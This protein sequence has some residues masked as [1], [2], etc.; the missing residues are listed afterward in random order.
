VLIGLAALVGIGCEARRGGWRRLAVWGQLPA[1]AFFYLL[2]FP[3]VTVHRGEALT[4]LTPGITAAQLRSI[5]AGQ[6]VVLLPGASGPARAQAVPD[7]ATALRRFP[8]VGRIDVIGAGLPARDRP[9]A[10]NLALH[11]DATAD[12]GLVELSAPS[13]A[14]VGRQWPVIGK[15]ASHAGLRLELRDPSGAVVDAMPATPDGRF[16]LS[17]VARGIGPALFSLH[18]LDAKAAMVD[19]ISVPVWVRDGETLTILLRAGG[20]SPEVKYW[21]RWAADSGQRVAATI[22]LTEGVSLRDGDAGLTVERLSAADLVIVDE[23]AW[24]LL[25]ADEKAALSTA[26]DGGL[27]LLLR[28]EGEADPA[29][30]ADWAALGFKLAPTA[31]RSVTLDQL[32]GTRDRTRFTVAPEQVQA[33]D[34][35][36]LW[37]ADDGQVLSEWRP[38]AAGRIGITRLVDTYRLSLLG[39]TGRYGNLWAELLGTIARPRP[40]PRMP[41]WPMPAWVDQRSVVCDLVPAIDRPEIAPSPSE[42][43]SGSGATPLEVSATGCA[44]WWPAESGWYWLRNGD[45]IGQWPVYVHA[46]NDGASLRRA[47]DAR[48]TRALVNERPAVEST[49]TVATPRSRWPFFIAWLLAISGLWWLERRSL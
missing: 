28:I 21:R 46:A 39:D 24:L 27:G 16:R 35:T 15:V 45:G 43:P 47:T 17:A 5:P 19:S 20:A 34:A 32:L 26:V 37:R 25:T 3:P 23:R 14:R 7:L 49:V 18:V 48:A 4:V 12:S 38:Q 36:P 33:A 10:A 44:A 42:T 30:V 41:V 22:G 1:A 11:F 9:S 29:V 8:G 13:I 2:L 40:Q 6:P 31:M